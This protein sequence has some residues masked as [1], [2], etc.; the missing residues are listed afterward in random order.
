MIALRVL[1]SLTQNT[2][3]RNT[4]GQGYD[5]NKNGPDLVGLVI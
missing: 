2:H 4:G 3:L 1:H 5:K